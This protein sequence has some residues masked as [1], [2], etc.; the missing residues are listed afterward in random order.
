[1]KATSSAKGELLSA[2]NDDVLRAD[3]DCF[4]YVEAGTWHTDLRDAMDEIADSDTKIGTIL[5]KGGTYTERDATTDGDIY[6]HFS[7]AATITIRPFDGEQVIFDG[8]NTDYLFWFENANCKITFN[9]ISF[10]KGKATKDGGA[11]EISEGQLTLNNCVLTGNEGGRYGGAISVSDGGSFIANNCVFTNNKAADSGGAISCED[12]GSVTLN[13]CYF[14]GNKV[15]NDEDGYKENDFGYEDGEG[16]PGSWEFYDCRF[17]GHGSIDWKLDAPS[18]S[19]TITPEVEDD[20]NYTVLYL[21]G[22][23]YKRLL[24]D[25]LNPATFEDLDAGTYTVYMM[26][27]WEK[28]YS[29]PGNTFTIVEPNFV[30]T[31]GEDIKV[32]ETLKDAVNAIPFG[33]TGE[34]AVEEGTWTGS[35]NFN[36]DIVNK[37]VTISPKL[38][39]TGLA[40]DVIFSSDS[41][42]YLF[43]VG[44]NGELH[45]ELLLRQK[46]QT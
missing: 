37:I 10:T 27:G 16:A 38:D 44:S 17:K 34:I 36:V 35:N 13:S 7:D 14:E 5:V 41:Q 19:V 39:I 6:I 26:K 3:T 21:N 22:E 42:N 46:I 24:C 45:M 43:S 12:D 18:K 15:G 30:L 20:V 25:N 9:D 2:S 1:M 28:R 29:Y 33:G 31:M 23:E 32:F 11:I 40:E 8:S 4:Y